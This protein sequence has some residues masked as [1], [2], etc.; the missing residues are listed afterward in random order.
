M[1]HVP[2]IAEASASAVAAAITAQPRAATPFC[3]GRAGGVATARLSAATAAL[4]GAL[5]IMAAPLQAATYTQNLLFETTERQS[6]WG[7]G[8]A[9]RRSDSIFLGD[10]WNER[11]P[12]IGGITGGVT[13]VSVPNP[14]R[15]AWNLCR[16]LGGGGR[17]GARPPQNLT[18]TIDTRTGAQVSVSTSGRAG[19]E[20]GY[21]LDAGSVGA[22]VGFQPVAQ[23]PQSVRAGEAFSIAPVASMTGGTLDAQSPTVN[24][25]ADA[26]LQLDFSASGTACVIFAGCTSASGRILNVDD[27]KEL[28]SIDPGRLL[29][30]DG[31]TPQD[32]NFE[33]L[34]GD[35]TAS[36]GVDIT[37]KFVASV[38]NIPLGPPAVG[39]SV[40]L[41]NIQFTPPNV[42][43]EGVAQDGVLTA[44]GQDR[45][46]ALN[47]DLDALFPQIPV[48]G[49]TFGVSRFD[50][51]LEAYDIEAGP[52]MSLFQDFKLDSRLMVDLAFDK[53]VEAEGL[54]LLT[55]LS[56]PWDALPSFSIFDDTLFTPTFWL[57]A[58]LESETGLQFGLALTLDLIKGGITF[59]P[60]QGTFGPL[61]NRVLP[62]DPRFAQVSL[63]DDIF[64][65]GGFSAIAG[66][67]FLV[68][69]A[70]DVAP[71]PVPPAVLLLASA[72]AAL[73]LARRREA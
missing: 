47:A 1:I 22:M 38:N 12:T 73:G 67:P 39:A 43:S 8:P 48:G 19:I 57:D 42:V 69:V 25:Y 14:A 66:D 56:S 27:Q 64:A 68:R 50:V 51:T 29:I 6:A 65:F 61:V 49:A 41:A 10:S 32:V 71:I 37:P 16:S 30:G 58:M 54:G 20:L 24:A 17:C 45:I 34:L 2:P 5:A 60:A 52:T 62:F 72:F 40:E 4:A 33:V 53:P 11:S 21:T 70:R 23:L 3:L 46:L 63:F 18:E 7:P 15:A 13:T 28:L 44:R 9:Q 59:G 55:A 36:F 35:V 26:V 31:F